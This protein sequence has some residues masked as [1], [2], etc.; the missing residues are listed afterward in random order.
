MKIRLID[1]ND[2]QTQQALIESPPL[3]LAQGEPAS[4]VDWA[5]P[6]MEIDTWQGHQLELSRLEQLAAS[7]PDTLEENGIQWNINGQEMEVDLSVVL[8]LLSRDILMLGQNK[9]LALV[10]E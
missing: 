7:I 8:T 3:G 2:E 10:L 1:T 5:K 4:V 6:I 9:Q